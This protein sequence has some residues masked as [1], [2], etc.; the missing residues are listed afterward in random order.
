MR[1][2]L[3]QGILGKNG[4][5]LATKRDFGGLFNAVGMQR[6]YQPWNIQS[7]DQQEIYNNIFF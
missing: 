5:I 7:I 2:H 6:Y 1:D 3:Q 4:V